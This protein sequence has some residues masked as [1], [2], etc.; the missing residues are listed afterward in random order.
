MMRTRLFKLLRAVGILLCAGFLYALLVRRTGWGIPCPV[1]ALTGLKCP[2][3]G[4]TRMAVS[5]LHGDLRAAFAYNRAVLCLLPAGVY[6]A[7]S[8]AVGYVRRGDRLLHGAP[9]A[10][11]IGILTVLLA[12]GAARNF[13]GW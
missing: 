11:A 9:K 10:A 8:Y 4:V 5:L 13:L 3:C 1:Y 12:F 2:G 7:L 6:V